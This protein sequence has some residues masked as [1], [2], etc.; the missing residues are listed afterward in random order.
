MNRFLVPW[1]RNSQRANSMLES[2]NKD[3]DEFFEGFGPRFS[4]LDER[5]SSMGMPKVNLKEDK[6][7]YF[8]EVELAG[9]KP[10]DVTLNLQDNTLFLKAE[11]KMSEKSEKKDVHRMESFYG[12]L[13]RTI[14]FNAKVDPE[15]VSAKFEN[16]ILEIELS[17]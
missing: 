2:F 11:K 1:S 7:H 6:E 3:F 17:K 13:Q 9:V 14:S 16:G 8:V 4:L 15:R 5:A 10:E 12:T